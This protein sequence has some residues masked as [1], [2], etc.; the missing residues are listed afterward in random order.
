MYKRLDTIFVVTN[1]IWGNSLAIVTNRLIVGSMT[2]RD[3]FDIK[4]AYLKSAHQGL[5]NQMRYKT[6][7]LVDFD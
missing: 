6:S 2:Q 7:K 1:F 5:S 4:L 3:K